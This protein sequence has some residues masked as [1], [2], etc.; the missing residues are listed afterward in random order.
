MFSVN[1]VCLMEIKYG[2]VVV[3]QKVNTILR[4]SGQ[5][6]LEAVQVNVYSEEQVLRRVRPLDTRVF[7]VIDKG[8][9]GSN[10][11]IESLKNKVLKN[12]EE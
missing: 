9:C 5:R 4:T 6:T 7:C 1:V 12:Q 11:T 3:S 2:S 10:F 8:V